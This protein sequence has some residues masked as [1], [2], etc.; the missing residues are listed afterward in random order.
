MRQVARRLR[1]GALELLEVPTPEVG[2]ASVLV[3]TEV[4][5]LSSGTERSTMKVAQA[6]LLQKARQRPDQARQV[7]E[8]LRSEGLR[9][10]YE[11]VRR[12]LDAYGPLGYS[13]AGVAVEVGSEVRTVRAGDR[14]AIAGAGHAN[15]AEV[16]VVPE[17]LCAA[18]PEGVSSEAAA[19]AT[20]GAIAMQ[21]FRRAE[22]AVGSTVAV[23]GLGLIGQLSVRIARAAGCKVVGIDL[24]APL[25]ELAAEAGA[26]ALH[27]STLDAPG[28]YTDRADAVLICASAP[29]SDDPVR[30]AA[31]L[32]RDR[33][34]VVAVGEVKM[35]LPRPPFYDKELDLRLSRSYGPGRYDDAYELHGRD[36]PI[37]YVR[38]TEQRN[39][40]SF[41]GL[42]ADGAI[43]PAE[44]ITHRFD[45]ERAEQAYELLSSDDANP[46]GIVFNYPPPADEPAPEK[47]PADAAR[48]PEHPAGEPRRWRRPTAARPRFAIA[49]A[50]A[51]AT[52]TV[53][54]GLIGAGLAPQAVASASGLS[55][56]DARGSFGFA[57]TA[58]GAE[59]LVDRDDVDLFVV[60]TQHDSHARL[61]AAALRRGIATYVEKPLALTLAELAEVRAAQRASGA[62]LWVG[63]NRTHSRLAAKLRELPGP[64][65]MSY[66]VN[67]GRLAVDHWTNDP[68]RGGGRLVGEGCHFIDF[69]CD[70]AGC[71]P[72]SVRATGF[73]ADPE[74][75]LVSTDNLSVQ[76][77]FADGSAANLNYAADSPRGPG[78]E[79]FE[80][81]S[82]GA[83]ARLDDY[84]E[85]SIWRG[86][87]R[88]KLG[89]RGQD[90]GWDAQY[91]AIA[92]VLGGGEQDPAELDRFF[93]SSLAT[94]AAARSLR[95]GAIEGVIADE[96][97]G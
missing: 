23:I 63:F 31:A 27:R 66:R 46:L 32:A 59:A 6:N 92:A 29:T 38:W 4:S 54:P 55:A 12:K 34:P 21:G 87:E 71:D 45:F 20:I 2:P 93:V 53:I 48:A 15:H 72:L 26:T 89:G 11:T 73:G 64:R 43:D 18:V 95:S 51:F 36:Y 7:V 44:L 41:L 35:D 16:C 22:V 3:R 75:P 28:P 96:Q 52:A 19:F 82:P 13:A 5:V 30:T 42:I 57:A 97:A 33:A 17:L 80:T 14:V 86:T 1:D 40:E 25:L 9:S 74:L 88:T 79:L 70:Q 83:Y 69:L 85:A 61:A 94:L 50:G 47:A 62:P 91:E 81:S 58:T 39:M 78:K 65:L 56:E 8:K 77:E 24:Q 60:A 49:G 10:T 84:R 90:K 68:A 37:G 67:A 76:I